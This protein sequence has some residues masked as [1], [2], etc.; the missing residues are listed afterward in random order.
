M[1]CKEDE[2]RIGLRFGEGRRRGG[3]SKEKGK[4]ACIWI[5][6]SGVQGQ[7]ESLKVKKVLY[8]VECVWE[9]PLYDQKP[10]TL[11]YLF[12][13]LCFNRLPVLPTTPN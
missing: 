7:R 2:I 13:W 1:L 4:D 9:V 3:G 5:R 6:D 8:D 12:T 11:H 10:N